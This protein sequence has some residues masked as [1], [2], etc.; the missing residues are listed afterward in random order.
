MSADAMARCLGC[1]A[2]FE[3]VRELRR[4]ERHAE[5]C[6]EPGEVFA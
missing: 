5:G 3:S 6:E 2:E 4:G 1:G